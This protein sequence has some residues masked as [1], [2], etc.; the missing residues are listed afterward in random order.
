[1]HGQCN[2]Y[3][4]ADCLAVSW[5]ASRP[6]SDPATL[7][8]LRITNFRPVSRSHSRRRHSL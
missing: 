7:T 8:P 6:V 2:Q 1:M 3:T 5:A 4:A